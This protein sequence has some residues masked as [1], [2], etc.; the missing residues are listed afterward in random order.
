VAITLGKDCTVSCGGTVAGVRNVTFSATARTIDIEAFAERRGEVYSVG[1]DSTV[2]IELNDDESI[3]VLFDSLEQGT[4]LQ[5]SGGAGGWS[6]PAIVTSI[7]ET[8]S[9]DGVA[10][11]TVEAKLARQLF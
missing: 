3:A 6:F 7:G 9:I 1:Y 4:Y 11:F 8:D 10:T 2:T 5:V